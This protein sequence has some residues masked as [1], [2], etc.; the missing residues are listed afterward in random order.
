MSTTTFEGQQL[1][2]EQLRTACETAPFLTERRLVIV[3]GLLERFESR[4][5]PN[6]RSKAKRPVGH[7]KEY[8]SLATCITQVPDS[9]TLVLVDGLVSSNNPLL[10]ELVGKAQVKSFPLLKDTKLWQWIERRVRQEGGSISPEA[11]NLLV[12]L[13]GS[14]LWTMTSEI[15]KLILFA[16]GRRIEETDVRQLVSKSQEA[17]V[18]AMVDAI[19][20]FKVGVAEQLLQRL[21]ESGVAPAY[22]LVMLSRQVRM[23]IQAIELINQSKANEEIRDKLSLTSEFALRKVLEQTRRYPLRQI[24]ELYHKLLET[25]LSIKTGKYSGELAL[26]M[27][28]ADICQQRQR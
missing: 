25:D 2:V 16:S 17:N 5:K 9:T 27:L 18:F 15:D 21:L 13:I 22:L 12:M 24:I 6:R 11:V 23:I 14:N 3:Y 7:E 26:N 1:T 20:E 28:V 10:R 19:L 4:I 8:K